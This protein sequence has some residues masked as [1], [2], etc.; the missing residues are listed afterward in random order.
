MP[1]RKTASLVEC[2]DAAMECMPCGVVCFDQGGVISYF[3]P[4]ASRIIGSS[5]Q[6]GLPLK[7]ACALLY[8]GLAAEDTFATKIEDLVAMA[9][10]AEAR[11]FWL[12]DGRQIL[13]NTVPRQ[14]GSLIVYFS[15]T[16]TE[17]SAKTEAVRLAAGAERVRQKSDFI[18]MISHELRTPL[19]SLVGLHGCVLKDTQLLPTTRRQ[20]ELAQSSAESLLNI[21]NDLLD[22][23][24]FD[25][26][27]FVLEIADLSVF[28]V[29]NELFPMLEHRADEKGLYLNCE[30]DPE[31]PEYIKGDPTR[32]R[33]VLVNLVGNALK[34]TEKGGVRV[35]VRKK[36]DD[37]G[38]PLISFGVSDT[39]IG[40]AEESIS[41]LFN[42]FEQGDTST[43]R[44]YGGTGLGLAI[45]KQIVSIMGGT[46][47]AQ[48]IIGEGSI[49][50]FEIPLNEGLA[51]QAKE[52]DL[53]PHSHQLN[54]LC[55]EDFPANQVIMRALVEDMG[56]RIRVVGNGQEAVDAL[57]VDR[58]DVVLMDGRMPFMD[59]IEATKIIRAGGGEK[60]PNTQ[61]DIYIIAVTANDRKEDRQKHLE[62]GAN[63]VLTK[64]LSETSL[65]KELAKVIDK[66]LAAG[67][68][69]E[70]RILASL[71]ELDAM[72]GFDD[73]GT[74]DAGGTLKKRTDFKRM[75]YRE[76]HA[77][78]REAFMRDVPIRLQEI[79]NAMNA[80]DG[81]GAARIFH[82][83]KGSASYLYPGGHLHLFCAELEV[84]A[85]RRQ[86]EDIDDAMPWLQELLT[87]PEN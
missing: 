39:G 43:N 67:V 52:E 69:L 40:I 29:L 6:N 27:R 61:K 7:E 15:D 10:T 33:Q 84:A 42:P 22:V 12:A 21:I 87:H 18:A 79:A 38:R 4:A 70:P 58:F 77:K 13:I 57:S 66:Q 36:E 16:T 17:H 19:A 85:D 28:D 81:E 78:M 32:I 68:A 82:G 86:W 56:H 45:C 3:N 11:V 62:A 30:I 60:T 75:R 71:S 72:F 74:E 76:L 5:C 55:A 54:I 1:E 65:S 47:G 34:F 2:L 31:L 25:S 37:E 50:T 8:A 20:V 9:K 73:G 59:G 83:L 53:G 80:R 24:R 26:G 14:D 48:S 46:I 49:F 63:A 41:R 44:K 51:P 35:S 64:P 23:A